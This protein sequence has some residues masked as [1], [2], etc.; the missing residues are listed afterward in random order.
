MNDRKSRLDDAAVQRGLVDTRSKARALILAGD[1]LVNGAPV[2]KAGAAVKDT[3]VLT[4]KAKPRF[5]SRGGE[6]LEHALTEFGIDVVGRVCADLGASTGGFTD[7]LLQR[8]AAKVYAVDVGYGQLDQRLRED[9][10]VVVMERTNA[11]HLQELPEVVS[12]VTI[13]VSFI[14]L[15]LILPVAARLL[16]VDGWCVPLIK[17]QF[18]AGRAEVGRKGVVRD[19]EIHRRVVVE[20]CRAAIDGGFG[21]EGLTRSPLVGPEG[22]A[23]FLA[24]LR[25]GRGGTAG[26]GS[27]SEWVEGAV[28]D[29]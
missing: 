25:R 19:M 14:S 3:D 1:L 16:A 11:R 6:K 2:V 26:E 8:G 9:P 21:V 10:R 24:C 12:L 18:E 7:C 4:V 15:R 22:N 23:E 28:T 27:W 17:P 5:V 20:I 13:D 29:R